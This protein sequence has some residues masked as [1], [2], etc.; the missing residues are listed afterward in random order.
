MQFEKTNKMDYWS[1]QALAI[2]KEEQL[3]KSIFK[4]CNLL[5]LLSAT[6]NILYFSIILHF[7]YYFKLLKYYFSYTQL[8]S[9]SCL[10][11]LHN[12]TLQ[13][14]SYDIEVPIGPKKKMKNNV[15]SIKQLV[16][17]SIVLQSCLSYYMSS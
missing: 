13:N 10:G 9:K 4:Q 16:N 12:L 5:E 11:K 2:I 17:F 14:I 3:Y 6:Y 1:C 7:C 8:T 15:C